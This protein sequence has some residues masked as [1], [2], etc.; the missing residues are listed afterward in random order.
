MK[1]SIL[2]LSNVQILDK[3]QQK[4]IS[5]GIGGGVA[6]DNYCCNRG[7]SV[8]PYVCSGYECVAQ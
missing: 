2:N 1:K 8:L 4:F 3:N 7:W 5:G 6:T